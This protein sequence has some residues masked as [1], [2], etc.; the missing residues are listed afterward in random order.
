MAAI[1]DFQ[2]A[3]QTDLLSRPLGTTMMNLVFVSQFQWFFYYPSHNCFSS[4]QNFMLLILLWCIF[5]FLP[6]CTWLSMIFL[7]LF[8]FFSRTTDNLIFFFC[9]NSFSNFVELIF[10]SFLTLPS[11]TTQSNTQFLRVYQILM[12][13]FLMSFSCLLPWVW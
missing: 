10:F 6:L 5:L 1:L 8:L 13:L 3:R 12:Y 7:F 2:V 9:V 11:N 4:G